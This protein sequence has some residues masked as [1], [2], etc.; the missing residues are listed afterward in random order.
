MYSI[1]CM[2]LRFLLFVV[3]DN[4]LIVVV[5]SRRA[6]GSNTYRTRLYS[7]WRRA[8]HKKDWGK[9]TTLVMQYVSIELQSKK[10]WSWFDNGKLNERWEFKGY[11]QSTAPAAAGNGMQLNDESNTRTC[12]LKTSWGRFADIVQSSFTIATVVLECWWANYH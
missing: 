6:R 8:P 2:N 7:M 1:T 3:V 10:H 4:H 11:I 12:F 5:S 9:W